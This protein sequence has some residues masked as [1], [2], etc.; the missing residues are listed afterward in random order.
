[1]TEGDGDPV[2]IEIKTPKTKLIIVDKN[3]LSE[4][5]GYSEMTSKEMD[6]AISELLS[7]QDIEKRD[8][9]LTFPITRTVQCSGII[10]PEEIIEIHCV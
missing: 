4:P 8:W 5:V 2:V 1:M 7:N 10:K 9:R 6:D 3:S